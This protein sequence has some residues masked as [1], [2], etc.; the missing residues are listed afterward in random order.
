VERAAL[1]TF[2]TSLRVFS[3]QGETDIDRFQESA[4]FPGDPVAIVHASSDGRWLFVVSPRYAAWVEARAIAE[5]DKAS[6]LGYGARTPYRVMTGAK[7][8]TLFT[9]EAPRVSE[10][11]LDMG[12]RVPL[13]DVSP[14]MPVN[15]QHPYTSWILD[16]PVRND[17]GRLAF[18]PALLPRSAES[19]ADYLP[20][21]RANIIGQAFRFLGERYGW[22]HAYNGRDCSG[23][24]SEIYR[25]MG[26]EM[27]RNTSDQAVSPVFARTRFEAGDTRAKRM[28]AVEA[29]DVGDL[30]YIPGHVMM[31]VG[32]IDGR[33]YVIHDTNGGSILGA[34]G[35]LRSLKL[36]GVSLTPLLPLRWSKQQDYVDRI[37]NIVRV[38]KD[39]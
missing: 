37:T 18:A 20:L 23:F 19:G 2:P 24:V 11:Q 35:E 7:P 30:I 3:S 16:V 27:P 12:V 38:A 1:R 31:F 39:Q 6:V 33:P 28:A 21:T 14:D 25:S 26:V 34:D 8:R 36:N 29:L 22:G 32:R 5:G 17:D 4:L 10:L 13:A 15:G 9:R